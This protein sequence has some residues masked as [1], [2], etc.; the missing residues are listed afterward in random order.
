[1]GWQRL[2]STSKG[3]AETDFGWK[4]VSRDWFQLVKG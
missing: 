2:V 4:R 3:L 1:M